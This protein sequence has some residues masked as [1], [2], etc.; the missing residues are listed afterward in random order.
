MTDFSRKLI[1]ATRTDGLGGRLMA[2]VNAKYLADNMGC[3]F[4]FTWNSQDVDDK[5]FHTADFVEKIFSADFIDRHWLGEKIDLADFAVLGKAK[6]ARSSLEAEAGR[7]GFQGWICNDFRV[8]KLFRQGW[9]KSWLP[10]NTPA[11][12]RSETF[13]TLGFSEAVQAAFDAAGRCQ[14]SRP[15]AT[16]HLRS[17][18]IVHGR[19]RSTLVFSDKVIPS[20]LARAIVS[21]LSSKGLATLLVGQ[22]RATLEYLKAETGAS[23]VDDFGA[24]QFEDQTVR[25]FFEMALMAR[26]RQIYAGSSVFASIASVMGGNAC[27]KTK[28]LFSKRRAAEIILQEL[29][30]RQP[31]YHPFEAAF[32]YRAAFLNLEGKISTARARE[33]LEKAAVLDPENHALALKMAAIYFREGNYPSGEAILKPLMTR[34]FQTRLKTPLPM[35]KTLTGKTRRGHTMEKDFGHFFAAAKAGYPYA[36]ACSAY[37]HA[38]LG[39]TKPALA[40]AAISRKAEPANELFQEIELA[41]RHG[42]TSGPK[43]HFSL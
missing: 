37:I 29:E 28:A 31:D 23:M 21:E 7:T 12:W 40:M 1:A 3:R 22:D 5:E 20:T 15:M 41:A 33:I 39:E 4:G 25:T 32:G 30:A 17:G 13:R 27:V 34:Q 43:A 2:M 42:A 19:F 26:C 10:G 14:F 35:F 8:L 24:S 36:A 16:L 9:A 18:D 38:G 11:R 6:F